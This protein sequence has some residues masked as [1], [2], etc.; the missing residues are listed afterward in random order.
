VTPYRRTVVVGGVVA[1]LWAV[2]AS[3]P[4]WSTPALVVAAVAGVALGV[5]DAATHRLPDALTYPT[6]GVVA[7]LLAGAAAAGDAWDAA[8]RAVLGAG[9]LGAGYLV[10]HLISPAGLGLG[11]VK[12]AVPLGMVSAWF[13]WATLWAAA[14]LPFVVGGVVALVLLA[15][16]RVTRTTAIAFGPFMLV[17]AVLALTLAR[18]AAA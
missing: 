12:L 14:L 15:A 6:T 11:D 17:G 3:G 8:L 1:A 10:L 5:I 7:V 4:G 13:G 2:W 9:A 16:R 18:L